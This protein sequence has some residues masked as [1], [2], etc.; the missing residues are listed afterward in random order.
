MKRAPIDAEEP[1]GPRAV[2]V[3]RTQNGLDVL[4]LDG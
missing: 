3:H 4:S 1:R 2:A